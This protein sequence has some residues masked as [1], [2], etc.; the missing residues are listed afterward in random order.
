MRFVLEEAI[1]AGSWPVRLR[2][3]KRGRDEARAGDAA[4]MNYGMMISASGALTSLY[5]QDVFANNLANA[6]TPGFAPAAPMVRQRASARIEDGLASSPAAPMLESLG[7]GVAL[8]PQ[9]AR[10]SQGTIQITGR[11]MDAAIQGE[12][13]LLVQGRDPGQPPAMTRDGRMLV[14]DGT[15]VHAA[16]GRPILDDRQRTIGVPDGAFVRVDDRGF[17]EADGQRIARLALWSAPALDRLVPMGDGLHALPAGSEAALGPAPGSLIAGAVE[18]SG[19]DE[20][21]AML[22]VTS[23]AR[24]LSA[25]M[26]MIR[27]HDRLLERAVNGLGRVA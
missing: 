13:F 9:R 18:S 19:V 4:T 23:A 16:S 8:A 6:S 27:N 7:A 20:I 10:F 2:L 12:G 21:N 17:V 14:L 26:S 5:E 3:R 25:H 22:A 1:P 15:V 24:G 11:P